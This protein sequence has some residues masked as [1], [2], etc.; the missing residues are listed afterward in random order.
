MLRAEAS[1]EIVASRQDIWA[2]LAEPRH[3]SDWW[4]GVASVQPDRRGLAPGARWELS[5]GS[6]PT[7]FRK[8]HARSMLVVREVD[9]YERVVFAFLQQKLDVQVRLS[10]AAPDRTQVTVTVEGPWRPEV[11]G[12]PRALP[13]EA[14]SRLHALVQTAAKL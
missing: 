1:R 13:G 5:G 10:V 3:L 7:L 9:L 14:L 12:R 4:P 2:F 6:E 11:L 8:P